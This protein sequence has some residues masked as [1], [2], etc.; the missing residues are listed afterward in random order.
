MKKL[1][2]INFD[3]QYINT[4]KIL[5]SAI[6]ASLKKVLKEDAFVVNEDDVEFEINKPLQVLI[7]HILDEYGNYNSDVNL[8][9]Y[10]ST[11]FEENI[12]S[13]AILPNGLHEFLLECE[14]SNIE[15]RILTNKML[16]TIK[17][18]VERFTPSL[19]NNIDSYLEEGDGLKLIERLVDERKLTFN[20]VL[21]ISSNDFNDEFLT[22][23]EYSKE[24]VGD[25]IFNDYTSLIDVLHD[26]DINFPTL[27]TSLDIE[28][29]NKYFEE[30]L[31]LVS[32]YAFE[33]D[34]VDIKN[35]TKKLFVVNR[36]EKVCKQENEKSMLI[37][38]L[39]EETISSF[40]EKKKFIK[41]LKELYHCELALS[42]VVYVENSKVNPCISPSKKVT[43]FVSENDIE[44]VY[45][46]YC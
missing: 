28:V 25:Y 5:T 16:K 3:N 43:K 39:L 32:K 8:L 11:Y 42:C 41:D 44:L 12:I 29:D 22:I 24:F 35:D 34:I 4:T 15:V 20:D 6:N 46:L 37:E 19:V 21:I 7:N 10:V 31:S 26:R 33:I 9:D 36:I 14:K 17:K 13:K 30:V 27:A 2:L 38:E 18:C 23:Y 40:Y 1:V 45:S